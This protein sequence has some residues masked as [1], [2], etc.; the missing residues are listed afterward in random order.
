[1]DWKLQTDIKKAEQKS[2]RPIY[3]LDPLLL[4]T[5]P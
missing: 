3:Y 2:P 4:Y 1:M 5:A